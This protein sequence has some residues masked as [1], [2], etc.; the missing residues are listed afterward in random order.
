MQ[1]GQLV[2]L[3][4][5]S[6]RLTQLERGEAKNHF[7][8]KGQ[9]QKESCQ[10]GPRSPETFPLEKPEEA[11]QITFVSEIFQVIQHIKLAQRLDDFF[12]GGRPAPFKKDQ[13]IPRSF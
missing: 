10:T 3:F 11:K 6:D 7:V 13:I 8:S 5:C 4:F 9:T 12:H 1:F 2:D